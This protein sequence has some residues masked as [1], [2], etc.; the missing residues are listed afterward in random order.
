MEPMYF[1]YDANGDLFGNSKGY[2]RYQDAQRICTRQRH[3]LWEIYD[4]RQRT[5]SNVI[6]N[7]ELDSSYGFK[8][9]Q[10][11]YPQKIAV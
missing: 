11:N 3:K 4:K 7:I 2:R 9:Q 5:E 6:W 10:K 8:W 1:I